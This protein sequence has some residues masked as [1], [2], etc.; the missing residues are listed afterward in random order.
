MGDAELRDERLVAALDTARAAERRP[1]H[2]E[3]ADGPARDA[4]WD[5]HGPDD[6]GALSAH[7]AATHTDPR[8]YSPAE[9]VYPWVDRRPDLGLASIYSGKPFDVERLIAEDLA[10][11]RR[12]E[13]RMAALAAR[14]VEDA[15]M[16]GE[17]AAAEAAAP[18]NCEHVVPQSWF[19]RREPMKGDL[20][21]LFTC[22]VRCNSFRQA[23]AYF[24]WPVERDTVRPECGR[25]DENRFEPEQGKG[26]VARATL[27]FL[28]RYPGMI[29]PEDMPPD[30]I[31]VVRAWHEADPVGVYERHRNAAIHAVQGNRNP[32]VDFPEWVAE[33]GFA[34]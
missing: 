7:L 33:I 21:H 3:A 25:Q 31:D 30:R 4:Y 11:E 15:E 24:Q 16:A 22:E 17:R 13:E 8:S 19:D 12:L 34:L 26:P 32:F 10:I 2:D 1:Y 23:D 14:G 27:Y 5:G 28:V 20:H 29:R 6:V 18:F 9:E